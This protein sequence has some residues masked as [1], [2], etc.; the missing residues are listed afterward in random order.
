MHKPELDADSA[1]KPDPDAVPVIPPPL[2]PSVS[3]SVLC[4]P[5]Q[6]ALNGELV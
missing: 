4:T 1:L 5:L 3:V 6:H 2:M